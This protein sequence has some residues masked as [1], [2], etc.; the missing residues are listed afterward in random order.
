MGEILAAR[1]HTCDP[2][3]A[4]Y[5]VERPRTYTVLFRLAGGPHRTP[6]LFSV[7]NFTAEC[8][9]HTTQI[10]RASKIFTPLI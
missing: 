6:M 5:R 8:R 3:G 9:I 1:E 4:L 10:M 7:F 2:I